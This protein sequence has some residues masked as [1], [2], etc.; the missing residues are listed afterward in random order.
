[1]QDATPRTTGKVFVAGM[2]VRPP[3]KFSLLECLSD[4]RQSSRC[5]TVFPCFPKVCAVGRVRS[6][7]YRWFKALH[8]PRAE[9]DQPPVDRP[10]SALPLTK[11]QLLRPQAMISAQ[12][13]PAAL[14]HGFRFP[15]SSQRCES[16]TQLRAV[17][18]TTI[19]NKTAPSPK[20][21]ASARYI[22]VS[23]RFHA[24][25]KAKRLAASQKISWRHFP[26]RMNDRGAGLQP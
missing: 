20:V 2:P 18:K 21:N 15:S 16:T 23:M 6:P 22:H 4:H 25:P 10:A 17:K 8:E 12:G 14:H 24:F 7:I 13:Q 26:C 11:G 19:F 5:W 1:M 3:A 9:R